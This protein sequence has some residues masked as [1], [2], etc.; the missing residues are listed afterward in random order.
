MEA[1]HS[2]SPPTSS[3]ESE[4]ADEDAFDTG[5][6]YLTVLDDNEAVRGEY[7]LL[8]ERFAGRPCYQKEDGSMFLFYD[9]PVRRWL[10]AT[11]LGIT[12]PMEVS[13]G[14]GRRYP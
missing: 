11:A 7:V 13:A 2:S 1:W 12:E 5:A 3:A 10:F 14:G 6:T 9:Q 4:A 8:R